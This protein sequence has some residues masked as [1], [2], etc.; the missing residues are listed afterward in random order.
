MPR[1]ISLLILTLLLL[2]ARAPAQRADPQKE[3]DGQVK[4]LAGAKPGDRPALAANVV[5]GHIDLADSLLDQA[6]YPAVLEALRKARGFTA[7]V[8]G[9]RAK[10]FASQIDVRTTL[11]QW[12]QNNDGRGLRAEYF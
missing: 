8:T 12:R 2:P 9:P 7:Q 5:Q 11:V 6:K 1:P 4:A 10:Q 3:L